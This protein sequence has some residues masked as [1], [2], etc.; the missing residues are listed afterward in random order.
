MAQAGYPV[1]ARVTLQVDPTLQFMGYA[2]HE[3]GQHVIVVAG[4][5]LDS[6]MLGG[7]LLHELARIY[8]TERQTPSHQSDLIH[9]VLNHVVAHVL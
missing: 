5:A 7:L 1:T 9:E 6:E 8:H 4:W 3:G 2:K